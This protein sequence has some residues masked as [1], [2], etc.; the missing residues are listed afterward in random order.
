MVIMPSQLGNGLGM[1]YKSL[2]NI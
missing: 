2:W 1:H